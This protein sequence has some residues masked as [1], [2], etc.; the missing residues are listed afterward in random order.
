MSKD[1][2]INNTETETAE[3]AL[4][5]DESDLDAVAGGIGQNDCKFIPDVPTKHKII[6]KKVWVKCCKSAYFCV[7][8]CWCY[9]TREC[10]DAWH[11]MER[12]VGNVWAPTPA[13]EKGHTETRCAVRDLNIPDPIP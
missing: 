13:F 7:G 6:D 2:E 1:K 5:L 10:I 4:N 11:K 3:A 9:G 8:K 12:V